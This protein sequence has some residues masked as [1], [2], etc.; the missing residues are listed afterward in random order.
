VIASGQWN[1][2]R[3]R[4]GGLG[5]MPGPGGTG[6]GVGVVGGRGQRRAGPGEGKR[7][8]HPEKEACQSVM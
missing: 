2:A 3:P 4:G 5:E 8:A 6:S 7:A 1:Q